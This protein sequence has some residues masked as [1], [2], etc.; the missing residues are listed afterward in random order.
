MRIQLNERD[1]AHAIRRH[2][3]AEGPPALSPVELRYDGARHAFSGRIASLAVRAAAPGRTVVLDE[4]DI[5][6]AIREYVHGGGA[7]GVHP[8][9]LGYERARHRFFATCDT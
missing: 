9:Q 3:G 6:R 1:I 4:H 8:V 2:V 5:A 7:T